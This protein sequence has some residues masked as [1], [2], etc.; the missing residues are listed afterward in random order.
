MNVQVESDDVIVRRADNKGRISIGAG[1]YAGK[2]VEVVILD[3]YED[4]A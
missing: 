1:D 3:S 4:K 2:K